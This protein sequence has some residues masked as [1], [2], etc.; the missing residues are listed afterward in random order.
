M[1]ATALIPLVLLPQQEGSA[2]D[3]LKTALG[4]L[5]FVLFAFGKVI[6]EK[7]SGRTQPRN[8]SRRPPT[9]PLPQRAPRAPEAE[10]AAADSE[11]FWDELVAQA[12][13]EGPR[14]EPFRAAL[15]SGNPLGESVSE[16]PLGVDLDVLDETLPSHAEEFYEALEDADVAAS[17]DEVAPSLHPAVALVD[18]RRRSSRGHRLRESIGGR[19]G[20]RRAI[21]VAEVL[22][23]PLALR[24]PGGQP[25]GR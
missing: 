1:I 19:G 15:P 4:L 20:W 6:L 11:T 9:K 24:P 8:P 12:T 5:L 25:G 22:A 7:L 10:E 13:E 21:V 18:R 3:L 16:A 2:E 14:T 17:R 23:P